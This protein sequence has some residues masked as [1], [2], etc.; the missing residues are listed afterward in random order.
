M[1]TTNKSYFEKLSQSIKNSVTLKLISIFILTMLLMIP[2]SMVQDLISEREN[3][4]QNTISEVSDKWANEQYV[5]GPIL[6]IPL[7]KEVL[8]TT[9]GKEG[10][11]KVKTLHTNL[12]ILPTQLNINGQ[13]AP[14]S[15]NRGIYEVVVYDSKL[16]FSGSF[17]DIDK[18]LAGLN[19]YKALPEQAFLTINISDLRGIK[20]EIIV[21]WND[22][23]QHVEPGTQIPSF[24][25]AGITVNDLLGAEGPFSGNFSFDLQLQGSQFL[26]FIPLGKETKVHLTSDWKDP[27]FSGSFLPKDRNITDAG[28]TADWQVL[29]LN[30]NFPQSW[31]GDRNINE[32]RNAS[33]GVGLLLPSNDYQ[34]SMRSA[35]YALLAISLTFL[36]FFL[37]EIF[38]KS[39]V[40]PFQYILIGL[41]LCLFYTLL[42]SI[43]EHANFNIAY[44]I[45]S[46]AIIGMIG[47][48]AR[49]ILQNTR[50][51]LVLVAILGFTYTF[52]Y[53]TMQIQDFALLIGSIGLTAILAFTMYITRNVNWYELSATRESAP[54]VDAPL[55]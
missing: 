39:K 27:G 11:E 34:K 3:L 19:G 21:K 44:L 46:I 33:F 4:Q 29:E 16:A 37:V 2:M 53:V 41:A 13:V 17:D 5:Y 47:L 25:P 31:L 54:A 43:S 42:V 36:T 23:N 49:S 1:E 50:Q 26:G 9:D 35:K 30:R 24:I 6:T 48:Y 15:L 18:A 38:N 45:S 40:H 8:E 22:T 20:E 52:V 28:F 7:E 12:H 32:V 14:K 51:T 10:E 55:H